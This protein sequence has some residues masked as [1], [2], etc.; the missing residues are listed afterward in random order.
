MCALFALF[1][2]LPGLAAAEEDNCNIIERIWVDYQYENKID[3]LNGSVQD[4]VAELDPGDFDIPIPAE[5]GNITAK[6]NDDEADLVVKDGNGITIID[7]SSFNY[8][9]DVQIEYSDVLPYVHNG[10]VTMSHW[11]SSGQLDASWEQAVIN[12]SGYAYFADLPFSTVTVGYSFVPITLSASVDDG[13]QVV[14]PIS[15]KAGMGSDFA[16]IR[17]FA[18]NT[19]FFGGTSIPYWI[20]NYTASTTANVWVPVPASTTALYC[21]WNITD[22]TASESNG[23]LV[24]PALF[25]DFSSASLNSTLWDVYTATAT[26]TSGVLKITTTNSTGGCVVGKSSYNASQ[27]ILREMAAGTVNGVRVGG[28]TNT[29]SRAAVTGP[30]TATAMRNY[31]SIGAW[32]KNESTYSDIVTTPTVSPSSAGTYNINEFRKSGSTNVFTL[33][34]NS[35]SV[36]SVSSTLYSNSIQTMYPVFALISTSQVQVCDYVLLRKYSASV[37][38]VSVNGT[39]VSVPQ[40]SFSANSTSG[41]APKV[42]AFTDSTT[43]GA[44]AWN[45]D[46]G[47][48]QTST[49]Q[50]PTHTYSTSGIFNVTL[51]ATNAAGY[52]VESKTAYITII[53]PPV[54][55]F[56][57]NV[58]SGGRP[59]TVRFTDESTGSPTSWSWNFGDGQTSTSQNPT[60]TYSSSGTFTVSLTATNSA[61]SDSET[62]SSYIS[63]NKV[64]PTI[65]WA[66]PAAIIYGTP[67]SPTQLSASANVPGSFAYGQDVGTIY[68]AGTVTLTT[69]FTPTDTTNYSTATASVSLTINPAASS[70]TW[71]SPSEIGYGTALSSAQLNAE[72]SVDGSLVYDPP[73]GTVLP[74]GTHELS[75]TLTPYSGNYASSSAS[76]YVTVAAGITTLTWSNPSSI[77]NGTAL[78]STQLNAVANVPGTFTYTPVAGTVLGV[79]THTLHVDF[80]PTDSENYDS[81][82]RDVS[83]TVIEI[84]DAPESTPFEYSGVSLLDVQFMDKSTN[85]TAWFWDFGDGTNST[86]QHPVHTYAAEGDYTVVL[87]ASGV[88]GNTTITQNVTVMLTAPHN[89]ARYVKQVFKPNM[90]SWDFISN[91]SMVYRDSAGEGIFFLILWAVPIIAMWGRQGSTIIICCLYC[92]SG[93]FFAAVLPAM[94]GGALMWMMI[95]GAA[96]IIYKLFVP[97]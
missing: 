14:I 86:E 24:F 89:Y 87:T 27:Y 94:F 96:G 75:V 25:D 65:T 83:I 50:S 97:D 59:L 21:E 55:N 38:T 23:K 53:S 37:P 68:D 41:A 52:S 1:L 2:L 57:A 69:T 32:A 29:S 18:G 44:T 64:A 95:L 12:E 20:E 63:I 9:Y 54:A 11:D 6:T 28:Y 30:T 51:N 58:T 90:T 85:S 80:T 60:H 91:I 74:V 36:S 26:Q 43:G 73:A 67:L 5:A 62:K 61:G 7:N 34:N 39:V 77:Y 40:A 10:Y 17:F 4:D 3:D 42:V 13:Y 15:Y 84:P 70:I 81:A 76:V 45:W 88:G 56:A 93:A 35:G 22:E 66:T 79:G 71:D 47:D 92:F 16:S 31:S 46:F 82:S 33:A 48:G 8:L 78:S 49:Q 72:G 19:S